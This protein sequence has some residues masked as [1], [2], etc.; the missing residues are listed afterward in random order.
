MASAEYL[1]ACPKDT[2]KQMKYT[3]FTLIFFIAGADFLLSSI[4]ILN[5]KTEVFVFTIFCIC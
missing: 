4:P 3:K 1:G 5:K 2:H